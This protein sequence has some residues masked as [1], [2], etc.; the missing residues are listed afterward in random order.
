MRH[1][2]RFSKITLFLIIFFNFAFIPSSVK[3]A[4]CTGISAQCWF[5]KIRCSTTGDICGNGEDA[6]LIGRLCGT[7]APFGTCQ[8]VIEEGPI[9]ECKDVGGTCTWLTGTLNIGEGSC[10]WV[11]PPGNCYYQAICGDGTCNGSET[12]STCSQ[13]CGSCPPACG[14][15]TCEGNET[16]TNCPDDCGSCGGGNSCS[17]T[18]RSVVNNC[19]EYGED[20]GSGTCPPGLTCCVTRNQA[21]DQGNCCNVSSWTSANGQCITGEQWTNGWYA[22]N[23]RYECSQCSVNCG[24]FDDCSPN[25]Q[26]PNTDDGT[27]GAITFTSPNNG[28]AVVGN[29]GTLTLSWS[30]ASKAESYQYQIYPQNT[31]C[32]NTYAHC[33]STN[34][35][36]YSFIPDPN[37]GSQYTIRVRAINTT[38]DYDIGPWYSADF[39]IMAGIDV[40][41]YSD[42]NGQSQ[43]I[44]GNCELSGATAIDPGTGASLTA[45]DS[46][47]SYNG[48]ITGS[49]GRAVVQWPTNGLASINLNPGTDGNGDQY[50]CICPNNCQFN[51]ID[52]P[53]AGLRM[54]LS[55]IDL[56]HSGWFQSQGGTVYAANKTGLTVSDPIPSTCT[57]DATCV[58]SIITKDSNGNDDSAGIVM[59]GG[60]SIDSYDEAGIQTGYITERDSQAYVVGTVNTTLR[61]NYDYF[62][63]QF[64]MGLN[65]EDDFLYNY[66]DAT[67]PTNEPINGRAYFHQGNMTIQSSWHV[68]D[69]ESYVIFINGDL[70]ISDP[71]NVEQL[72]QVDEG[73][74]LAF[75]VSGDIIVDS[76]VGNDDLNDTS[77]NIEGIYIA[78]GS[79]T[80]SGKGI[81]NGG[82]ERFVGE[83]TFVGW[84][85]VEL[86]R[87][88]DDGN[89]RKVENNTRPVEL[90]VYR[91]DFVIYLPERMKTSRYLWQETN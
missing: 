85:G 50:L 70:T 40:E 54:Y 11:D 8:Q 67:K 45:S 24:Q 32:S 61:E 83:G 30:T 12:C 80:I 56:S 77:G 2:F 76:N 86:E 38:C 35:T 44:T 71:G 64:S 1:I 60:G 10:E 73:G 26:C 87:D 84:S 31:S 75:I 16:C 34:G 74:F 41:F 29:N 78:G 91:P 37:G 88:F 42:P 3:A 66:T 4:A 18:C 27:P 55:S 7:S 49:T 63:R 81:S 36:S 68:A 53:E 15:G 22:C 19:G 9:L 47:G 62:Y 72:I 17:G 43:P 51:N 21:Q 20:P 89:N 59:T 58:D 69:G 28:Q 65:P 5:N 33:G 25:N 57:D 14:D 48:T 46:Y 52:A 82:D 90:F 79:L 39:T 13:D 23:V 6:G